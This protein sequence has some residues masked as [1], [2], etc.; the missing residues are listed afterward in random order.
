MSY[1][2]PDLPRARARLRCRILCAAALALAAALPDAGAAQAARPDGLYAEIHTT[3]GKIV[4][5]LEP[6]LTPLAVANYVGLAEGT[7]ENAA[8]DAGRPFYDGTII[9][10]VAPGHVIQT[11]APR[12]E[13]ADGPGYTFPNEIHARLSHDHAGALNFANGGPHTNAGQWCIT[14]GD[15]SYLDG[16]Y[17]VFGEVVEGLDVVMRIV[18]GDVV[19]SVR[20]ARVGARA[21]GYRV[22][23]Q[24]F[25]ALVAAAERRVAEH[26]ARKR[27]AEEDWIARTWPNAA[28]PADSVRT[29]QLAAGSGGASAGGA[30][31]VRYRGTR[32]RYL[33]HMLGYEGPPLEVTTFAS[34]DDGVP[35]I[36]DAPQTF[37][38]Q[39]GATR[40]N[41][42]VDRVIAAMRPG[43]RRV[44]I[45][46][47]AL[48][49]GGAGLYT[50][51]TPGRPRFVI[52]PNTLLVYE[53]EVL[54]S[55]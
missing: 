17:I 53:I 10:R 32:V 27:A 23:T 12:S 5:R 55:D 33:A 6:D 20:I 11:G 51:E 22:D 24:S 9:H 50:R 21:R 40:I 29:V 3:K 8:F 54:P 2:R 48:G 41:P 14:L 34:G 44:A 18:Q 30:L 36:L 49:Y 7:I 25:R 43:E 47:A 13:R 45:V 31:R 39:P 52:S 16:D 35:G 26:A 1:A 38:F 28:G 37:T 42:G 46:P 15:R 4:A 19:D